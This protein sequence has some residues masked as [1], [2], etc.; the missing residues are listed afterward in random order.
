MKKTLIILLIALSAPMILSAQ[1]N[2]FKTVKG[3][4]IYFSILRELLMYYV[5]SVKIDKLID[6]SID[7]MLNSLDPY[8]E[9]VPEE[10]SDAFDFM[11]TGAYGGM[12]ALIRKTEFGIQ[13]TDPYKGFPADKAGLVPGDCIIEID[14][15]ST[16]DL[17]ATEG[18]NKLK[19]PAGSKLQLK[20]VKIKTGDTVNLAITRERIHVSDVVYSGVLRDSVGYIL[21][22]G[23][24]KDG[25]KDFAKAF[26]TLK[27]SDKIKSLI[28]DLR[29]NGGGS[30]DEAVNIL[31]M[32]IPKGTNAVEARGRIKEFEIIYKTK[33]IERIMGFGKN[34]ANNLMNSSTFPSTKIGG[35]WV[36]TKENFEAWL[37]KNAHKTIAL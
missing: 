25:S 18:S 23:F 7:A 6:T 13:I 20:V 31:S 35:E 29:S 30:L 10:Q 32:F 16:K 3:T 8:T 24:T 4:D 34:K 2:D 15:V 14:G 26:H 11:L 1:Q 28:I 33:D 17:D 21:L 36:V 12:G 22:S 27:N 9:Y 19:G 37:A 5:D